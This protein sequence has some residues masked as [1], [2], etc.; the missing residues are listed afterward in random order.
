MAAG[1][2]AYA[3]RRLIEALMTQT[4]RGI[5]P[6]DMVPWQALFRYINSLTMTFKYL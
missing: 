6:D 2:L 5:I 4:R 1:T 3:A